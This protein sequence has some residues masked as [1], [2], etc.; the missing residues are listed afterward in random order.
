[1]SEIKETGNAAK[2]C[3]RNSA[4]LTLSLQDCK[5][6]PLFLPLNVTLFDQS[7]RQFEAGNSSVSTDVCTMRWK[8]NLGNISFLTGFVD[9]LKVRV[10][11][12]Y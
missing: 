11:L 3:H 7:P 1:M 5:N 6:I 4:R 2:E 12:V 8:I 9:F 10:H